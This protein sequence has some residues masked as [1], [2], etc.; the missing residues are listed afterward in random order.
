MGDLD[1]DFI[2]MFNSVV[3][4]DDGSDSRRIGEA[5]IATVG[6]RN[7][8]ELPP[9]LVDKDRL[10]LVYEQKDFTLGLHE[11]ILDYVNF[12]SPSEKE[13]KIREELIDRVKAI[14]YKVFPLCEI[15][16]FGSF[17]TG[18][19]LST[20]DV[21]LVVQLKNRIPHYLR[22]LADEIERSKMATQVEAIDSARVPIVK[23]LDKKTN[24]TVDIC[25]NNSTSV[26][27]FPL[28][29]ERIEGLPA[30]KPLIMVLKHFLYCRRLN[31]T[32]YGGIGSFVL[33]LMVSNFL[34]V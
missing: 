16:V 12:I 25:F 17:Q 26:E 29:T 34:K 30:L 1:F 21:D 22:I 31:E 24:I 18:L 27:A 13:R 5:R 15:D 2:P 10:E 11:E 32:Y 28:I 23:F 20:S 8:D 3:S 14:A 4:E 7:A 19:Y 9:W 6:K 33:L